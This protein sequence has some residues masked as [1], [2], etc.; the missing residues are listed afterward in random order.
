MCTNFSFLI[1]LFVNMY[2]SAAVAA[3]EENQTL[4]EGTIIALGCLGGALVVALI[5]GLTCFLVR[6]VPK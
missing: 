2:F 5:L 3:I 6:Y 4:R 1:F